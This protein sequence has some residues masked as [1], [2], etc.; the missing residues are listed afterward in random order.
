MRNF[1]KWV[2]AAIPIVLGR[3]LSREFPLAFE[4]GLGVF[5][6]MAVFIWVFEDARK[7]NPSPDNT[8]E[9]VKSVKQNDSL[10][11]QIESLM[12]LKEKG[13]ITEAEMK[14]KKQQILNL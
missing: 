7:S 5:I 1:L 14:K 6:I 9:P 11:S 4:L 2:G 10:T 12:R 3:M 13:L 8:V